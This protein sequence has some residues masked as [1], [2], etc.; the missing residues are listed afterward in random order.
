MSSNEPAAR[1][2]R[3]KPRISLAAPNSSAPRSSFGSANSS[4][5]ASEFNVPINDDAAERRR[6]RQS[7]IQEKNRRR[8]QFLAPGSDVASLKSRV[9]MTP[10]R[11][12][13]S[14]VD[15]KNPAPPLF[16]ASLSSEELNQRYEEWMKVVA[17]GKINAAN[18]W[19]FHLIDYF[20]NLDLL[21]DQTSKANVDASSNHDTASNEIN[22]QKASCTLDGCVKIYTTRVDAVANETGRL[23]SGL[24]VDSNN[25]IRAQDE[26]NSDTESL[27]NGE[28]GEKK[29]KKKVSFFAYTTLRELMLES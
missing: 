3:V 2:K 16:T 21:S 18:S 8:S 4:F 15:P 11:S 22:F 29:K 14:I 27:A 5:A 20:A 12:R 7:Q 23:L 24:L 28:D 19:N 25:R 10:K 6:R 17:D 13:L 26:V 1:Q 9:S